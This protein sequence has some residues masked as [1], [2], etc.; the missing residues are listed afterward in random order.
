M[1]WLAEHDRLISARYDDGA[2]ATELARAL[3]AEFGLVLSRSAVLGRLHR[4]GVV[5]GD[6]S[7]ERIRAVA[8]RREAARQVMAAKDA[9][10]RPSAGVRSVS[11]VP[12]DRKG[13]TMN[14]RGTAVPGRPP[15]AVVATP[16]EPDPATA[17]VLIDRRR[18]QCAFPREER[19]PAGQV[20]VCGGEVL[21]A[22]SWCPWHV[23]IV[24]L[25]PEQLAREIRNGEWLAG[26]MV[27]GVAA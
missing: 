8:A 22:G 15:R 6:A 18:N 4:L 10:R 9:A 7:P 26:R 5:G 11:A 24:Y 16:A 2:S 25:K 27:G 3:R 19:G 13:R 23:G 12:K 20:M 21:D 14:L 17:V 1:K